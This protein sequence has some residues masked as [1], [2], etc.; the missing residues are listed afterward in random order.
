MR[1]AAGADRP[2]SDENSEDSA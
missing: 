2:V 1:V